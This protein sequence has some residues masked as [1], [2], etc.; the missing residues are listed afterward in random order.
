[1]PV[2]RSSQPWLTP[3]E[4]AADPDD[5]LACFR[6]ILGRNPNPEEW[7]G[8]L[9]AVGQ[10]LAAVVANFLGSM[11]FERRGLSNRKP[12]GAI[13]RVRLDGYDIF[14]SETDQ[15]VGRHVVHGT[16]EPHV[17]AALPQRLR[18]RMGMLDLGANIGVFALLAASMVGRDG[19]VLAM[20][21]N[22][23]NA[24]LLE[25]SR[26]ANGYS[27]LTVCQAAA[28]SSAGVLVL[29]SFDSNG[30]VTQAADDALLTARTVAAL[31]V[32]SLVPAGQTVDLIKIDVEGAEH[33]ALLGAAATLRRCRPVIISEY[34]PGLL[35]GVS[36]I[37]GIG[38]LS[39][40]ASMSYRLG[41]IAPDGRCSAGQTVAQVHAAYEAAGVDHIDII[42]LP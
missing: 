25:A 31:T 2:D 42:A 33:T 16:Y 20:E 27:H 13:R 39:F 8:H 21:P 26:R 41:V 6:L 9:G 19:Y 18:P 10:P 15:A 40:L 3:Y 29:H 35:Q 34:S 30:T 17:A 38:Y 28:A 7:T 5:I 11:E 12:D 23:D 36:G 37:D 4:P 14:A 1:M 24:R 32:D 22:P